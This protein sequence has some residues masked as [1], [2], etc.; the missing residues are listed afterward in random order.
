MARVISI[1]QVSELGLSW[2][3][4]CKIFVPR[5]EGPP[6]TTQFQVFPTYRKDMLLRT[7]RKET[8]AVN[9]QLVL[10]QHCFLPFPRQISAFNSLPHIHTLTL[11]STN[12]YFDA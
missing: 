10:F 3:S 6:L 7:V 8:D 2:P 1:T 11:Y 9:Q 5:S 12:S 4:C